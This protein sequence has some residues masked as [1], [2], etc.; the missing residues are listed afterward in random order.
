MRRFMVAPIAVIALA[1]LLLWRSPVI[2]KGTYRM[3]FF[4]GLAAFAT[5]LFGPGGEW[6]FRFGPGRLAYV[7]WIPIVFI[8]LSPYLLLLEAGI[9]GY[10]GFSSWMRYVSLALVVL[11][12][13]ALLAAGLLPRFLR[14]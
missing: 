3:G 1:L 8:A 2:T 11:G 12:G 9:A 6:G 5:F 4:L 13:T 10:R 14:R 7:A